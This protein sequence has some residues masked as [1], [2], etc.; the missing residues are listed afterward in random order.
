MKNFLILVLLFMPVW[1]CKSKKESSEFF[2]RG[3]YHFKK[4]ELEKAEH[5][6]TEAIKKSPDFADAYNNRG[7]V[8]LKWGKNQDAKKDF[9]KAVNLDG[10]FTEAKFNL[11]KLLSETGELKQAEALFKSIENKMKNSSDFYNHFG[12]NTVKLNHFDEGLKALEQSLKL[13]PGNVE[14]LTNISYVFL[15]QNNEKIAQDY[16]DKALNINPEFGFALNNKAV[17]SGRKRDFKNSVEMLE[18]ALIKDPQNQVFLNNAALYYLENRELEKGMVFLEKANKIDESNPYS[19][20]NQA[21]YL[22]YSGKTKESYSLFQ[23]IEKEN[24][25]VDH[26]YYYLSKN[27]S[28]LHDKISACKYRKTGAGLSEP[29]ISELPEC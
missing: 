2:K 11:A 18:K 7:A 12:Q 13:N 9:E 15:V 10:K 16:I 24:P 14:A 1:G 27:A 19:L 4:N 17:I 22:F 21:I 5:F 8:Y 6:F 3:N 25:E 29:W 28:A 23:K 26:I 20:R